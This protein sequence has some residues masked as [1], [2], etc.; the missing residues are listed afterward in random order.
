M[1]G[2]LSQ[3]RPQFLMVIGTL[4]V[5]NGIYGMISSVVNA[6]AP[7]TIDDRTLEDF[8]ERLEGFSIPFEA[9]K[10]DLEVY[11]L[12]TLLQMQNIAAA[13]F[14]FYGLSLFGAMMMLRLSRNGFFL[15]ALAQVGLAVV[16]A[17]FGG[18]NTFGMTSLVMMLVWNGIWIAVYGTQLKHMQ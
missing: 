18:F 15:Y 11:F 9:F 3:K 6:I 10:D 13:S 12:N 2:E 16:P 17:Y 14:L 8:F 4:S 1:D 7:T 5:I